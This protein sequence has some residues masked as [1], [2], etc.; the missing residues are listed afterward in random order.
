[1]AL[2]LEC[3]CS[4]DASICTLT[5][6]T[7]NLE[8]KRVQLGTIG[9]IYYVFLG[10]EVL[11]VDPPDGQYAFDLPLDTD[12]S[13]E[14]VALQMDASLFQVPDPLYSQYQTFRATYGI[15]QDYECQNLV[16][17]S[18]SRTQL[19]SNTEVKGPE[20]QCKTGEDIRGLV[21][22]GLSAI[23]Y[24][25][26][27]LGACLSGNIHTG[28][29]TFLPLTQ[30]SMINIGDSAQICLCATGG[31]GNYTYSIVSGTLPCGIVLNTET[32]CLDGDATGDCDGTTSVTFRVTDLG[33]AGPG[34]TGGVTIGGSCRVFGTGATRI[35]GG[36]W[37]TSMVGNTITI[38]GGLYTVATVA[39]PS[40]L[41]TTAAIGIVDPTTWSY[42]SPVVP[43]PTPGPP[44]I[45]EVTCG[46]VTKCPDADSSI[47]GNSAY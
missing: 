47:G 27:P 39:G 22:G 9:A 12:L 46:F 44:E 5:R 20:V 4:P 7:F 1:M 10:G 34:S 40:N 18:I 28:D 8:I 17:G 37:D 23:F 45:A 6:L 15:R 24:K 25:S 13:T 11:M 33:G 42:T 19:I 43:P 16:S 29:T 21:V 41:T 36:A 35:S 38:H 26:T 14:S 30:P 32:G 2:M 3:L 31:S